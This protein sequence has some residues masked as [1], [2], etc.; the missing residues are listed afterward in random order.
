M[1]QPNENWQILQ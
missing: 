1:N